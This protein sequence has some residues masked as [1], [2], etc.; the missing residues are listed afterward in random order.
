MIEFRV[1]KMAEVLG[2]HRNTITNWIRAGKLKA[3]ASIAKRY[4]V[5]RDDLTKLFLKE[6]IPVEYI[7]K[8]MILNG[9]KSK[10]SAAPKNVE[11]FL[12]RK[13]KSP[14]A[15]TVGSVMVV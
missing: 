3:V 10:I 5:T 8:L 14:Q 12:I 2:V 11:N 4:I 7:D 1:N 13:K 6:G 15:K 9:V